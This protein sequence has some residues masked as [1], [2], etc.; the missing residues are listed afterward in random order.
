MICAETCVISGGIGEISR[1]T[2]RIGDRFAE[3]GGANM[4]KITL[5]TVMIGGIYARIGVRSGEIFVSYAMTAG[6][7]VRIGAKVIA[8]SFDVI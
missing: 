2:I 8:V 7:C 6:N 3:T 1:V 4:S 5:N